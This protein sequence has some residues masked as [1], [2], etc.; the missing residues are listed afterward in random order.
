MVALPVDAEAIRRFCQA[1]DITELSLFG[2][3]IR[4]DFGADSD[5]DVLVEF[6]PGGAK[7]LLGLVRMQRELAT[8]LGCPVDVVSKRGLS[9][10]LRERVLQNR[11]VIYGRQG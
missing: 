6:A 7:S 10:H 4:E 1:H 2:S 3:V 9:R 8:M 11:E 5:V